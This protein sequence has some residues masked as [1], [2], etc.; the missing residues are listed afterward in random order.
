MI[1]EEISATDD[2]KGCG[3]PLWPNAD[4]QTA[5]AVNSRDSGHERRLV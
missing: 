3:H 1:P 5:D 4:S 2:Y